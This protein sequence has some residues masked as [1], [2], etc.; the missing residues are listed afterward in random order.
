MNIIKDYDGASIEIIKNDIEKNKIYLSLKEENGKY[1]YYYNFIIEN[2]ASTKGMIYIKNISNSQYYKKDEI[3]APYIKINEW[4]KAKHFYINEKEELVIN[5]EP[6]STQEIALVPRYIE[7]DL[8]E[9]INTIDT[10]NIK[11][12]NEPINEIIIGDI[13]LP[14]IVF[15][16]RQHPGETLSSFFI[17]GVI[18]QILN[19]NELT[20]KYCFIFYPL[21]NKK[22]VKNGN[23]RY[24]NGID[25]NRS[26]NKKNAPEEIKYIKEKLKSVK[27]KYFVDVHNDEITKKNYIRTPCR[28]INKTQIAGI[29]VLQQQ[30]KLKRFIRALIKQKKVINIFSKTANEYVFRKYHCNTLLIEISMSEQYKDISKLGKKFIKELIGERL[31]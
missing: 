16:A 23:H 13:N 10:S 22:G 3:N 24:T 17:E 6:N 26:W 5:I 30:S 4:E 31:K 29:Q 20:E 28:N 2:P 27:V 1:S 18:Q 12:K 15:I 25:Y 21:V 14:A 19:M 9:F 11:I 7:K 8:K